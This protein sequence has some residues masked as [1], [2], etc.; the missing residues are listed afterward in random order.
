M[1]R[2]TER[3]LT[4]YLLENSLEDLLEQLDVDVSELFEILIDEGFVDPDQ[5]K[6]I[7]SL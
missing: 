7:I 1:D 3:K 5:L 4:A 6:D 2:N